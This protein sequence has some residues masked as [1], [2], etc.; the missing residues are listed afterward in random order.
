M[1]FIYTFKEN[2]HAKAFREKGFSG[3]MER[4]DN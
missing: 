1:N 3:T 4:A 2:T